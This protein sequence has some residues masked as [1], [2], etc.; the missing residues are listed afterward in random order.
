M[1]NYRTI[2]LAA[3]VALPFAA[4]CNKENA[5]PDLMPGDEAGL[6]AFQS[7]SARIGVKRTE[8]GERSLVLT[9]GFPTKKGH[10]E[11]V[12]YSA[13]LSGA[14][15]YLKIRYVFTPVEEGQKA[16]TAFLSYS[17]DGIHWT[18]VDYMLE[19]R[20][21]LDYFTGYRSGLYCFGPG[22]GTARFDWF[23]QR[24]VPE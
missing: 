13:P 21:T 5:E 3:L 20:Y 9:E 17:E 11:K 12:I 14:S 22:G 8:A 6:C 16:D 4:A 18:A 24:R 15:V 19:M 2:L 23:H 10:R 1:K 7:F